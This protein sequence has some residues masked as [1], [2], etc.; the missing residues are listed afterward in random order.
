MSWDNFYEPDVDGTQGSRHERA[1]GGPASPDGRW[2]S[3]GWAASVAAG[4]W[5]HSDEEEALWALE[6]VT[7]FDRSDS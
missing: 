4:H 5:V 7:M 2:F 1:H 3:P 6:Q